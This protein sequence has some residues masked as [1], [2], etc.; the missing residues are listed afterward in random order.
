MSYEAPE[1]DNIEDYLRQHETKDMLRFIT[2]GSVDDGK[3]TLIGRL[4]HDSKVIFEDQLAAITKDSTRHGTTGEAVDLALLVDGLQSEREQGITIDVA[5]RFFATDHRKYI[6]ADTPG[7]EQYTRNMATGA[8]TA[9]VAILLI[10]ARYGVQVQTRRHSFICSLLGIRHFI[11][12]INKM[13]LVEY[14]Q[15]RYDEIREEYASFVAALNVPD[16]RYVPMSALTGDN[17]VHAST[18]MPWFQGEPLL[19][20]LDHMPVQRDAKLDTLRLPVQY[21]N[22]PNLD[23]R[24][25]C[26]T[27]AAGVVKP[28]MPVRA[29]PSGKT[30]TVKAIV[31]WEGEQPEAL[32]GQAI[33]LTLNDEIDISRGDMLVAADDAV[34]LGHAFMAHVVWMH[35]QPLQTGKTYDFKLGTTFTSGQVTEIVHQIDVNTLAQH[36]AEDLPLNGIA[37]C[38]VQLTRAVAF[39]PY[40]VC[41]ATGS[42]IVVDRLSNV[43]VGAGMVVSEAEPVKGGK[44]LPPVTAESR[45]RRLGQ[46]AARLVVSGPD[47]QLLAGQLERVLFAAGALPVVV[48]G[49]EDVLAERLQAAGL[50]VIQPGEADG[51]RRLQILCGARDIALSSLEAENGAAAETVLAALR[52]HHILG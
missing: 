2:C 38:R 25:Y 12:A 32:A 37:L 30:S 24:G 8:S 48:G 51:A 21:V 43:T 44:S 50:L 3:S 18:H 6:I 28:G 19:T 1:I 13:D 10:D 33:T 29:L 16:V 15:A 11:I 35:D 52:E 41:K 22:R 23:F 42:L 7:H 40:D 34:T 14:S 20:L 17:V 27:L 36:A 26:G 45:A 5:Y 49:D 4:L 39:D 31:T 46:Q 47:Q 9:Q